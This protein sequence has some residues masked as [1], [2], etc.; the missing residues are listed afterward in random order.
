VR[1]GAETGARGRFSYDRGKA[2]I[3]RLTVSGASLSDLYRRAASYVEAVIQIRAAA[4]DDGRRAGERLRVRSGCFC[5]VVLRKTPSDQCHGRP[6][7]GPDMRV[8]PSHGAVP[9]RRAG[10]ITGVCAQAWRSAPR[11]RIGLLN[12]MGVAAA[13]VRPVARAALD[14]CAR[15]TVGALGVGIPSGWTADVVAVAAARA[16]PTTA[17]ADRAGSSPR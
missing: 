14:D 12:V 6:S 8:I 1:A 16:H 10:R 4:A 11:E 9:L 17:A 3:Y 2:V 15:P 7:N 5:D 13:A